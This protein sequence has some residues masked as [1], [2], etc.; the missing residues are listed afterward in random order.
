MKKYSM[1]NVTKRKKVIKIE[2]KLVNGLL[3]KIT[4]KIRIKYEL[5]NIWLAGIMAH[6]TG[7]WLKKVSHSFSYEMDM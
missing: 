6:Y 5:T 2:W 1:E 7:V 3:P 4:L